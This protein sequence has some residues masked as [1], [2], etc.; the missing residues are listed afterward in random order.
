MTQIRVGGVGLVPN[1]Y[2]SINALYLGIM[3]SL[4][5]DLNFKWH[6]NDNSSLQKSIQS[7]RNHRV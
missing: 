2:K 1:L 7:H 6:F 3:F 5:L 4:A